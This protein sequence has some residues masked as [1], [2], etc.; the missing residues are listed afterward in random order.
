MLG[1]GWL[2]AIYALPL[3]DIC[4]A[5]NEVWLVPNPP[6]DNL[7]RA[8]DAE[9]VT[10]TME[11]CF[12]VVDA[13]CAECKQAQSGPGLWADGEGCTHSAHFETVN[14]IT[15]TATPSF[16]AGQLFSR[17]SFCRG[18][19]ALSAANMSLVAWQRV[20]EWKIATCSRP[21]M[22]RP[23]SWLYQDADVLPREEWFWF[24]T[25]IAEYER[26]IAAQR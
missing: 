6:H 15:S 12:S 19:T 7:E 5:C 20:I 4:T 24:Y 1:V 16:D 18:H 23:T 8:I 17:L 14:R 11:R 21:R 22:S 13:A 26:Q 2:A 3:S 25:R 10:E 9:N